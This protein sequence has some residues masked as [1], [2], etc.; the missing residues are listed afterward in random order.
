MES[1]N[2]DW[3]EYEQEINKYFRSEYPTSTI[4][5]NA[6]L[7]GRFSKIER[8]IDLL[9]EEQAS[10]FSFRIA[11][12]AKHHDKR[13]DV[14]DVEQFLGLLRDIS[15][16]VGVLIAP[17]G[18]SQ[19]AI[20]RAHYD[21]SRLELDVLNFDELKTFQAFGAIPYSGDLGVLLPAPFGWI[22][23]GIPRLESPACLYQ[24][25]LTLEEAQ[26]AWEWMYVNFWRR[27]EK[28]CGI[29]SLLKHQ[30][31]YLRKG[32]PDAEVTF[33][34]SVRRKDGAKTVIR[35]FKDK[36]YPS[37]EFTGF[38]EFPSFIFFCVLF[39]P[40]ELEEKN[41]RKLRY[42]LRRVLPLRVRQGLTAPIPSVS[43]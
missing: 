32:R 42:I 23:D 38:V 39:T 22:V 6:K 25:G 20:N 14:N 2:L 26:K 21:D 30:E 35:A 13:L 4:T 11:I 27:D 43:S 8:Q 29:E 7:I 41:L 3:Q 19:A 12:D 9:V 1:G 33:L 36:S 16:D 5:G 24:R 31:G 28:C 18:Y 34:D 10:D 17:M 40:P 15:A 37:P